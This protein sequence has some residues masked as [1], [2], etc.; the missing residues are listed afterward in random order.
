MDH[1]VVAFGS[2][3]LRKTLM[4]KVVDWVKKKE[5]DL[6]HCKYKVTFQPDGSEEPTCVETCFIHFGFGHCLDNIR[7]LKCM[8]AVFYLLVYL[9]FL[10]VS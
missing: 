5:K 10:L 8:F 2:N 3:R 9:L 1:F 7:L 6:L 4:G